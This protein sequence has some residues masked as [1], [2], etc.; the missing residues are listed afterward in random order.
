MDDFSPENV[1]GQKNGL[2]GR[3]EQ[4]VQVL[5]E[6]YS[7]LAHFA[8]HRDRLLDLLNACPAVDELHD[9]QDWEL[10]FNFVLFSE[11]FP[12]LPVLQPLSEQLNFIRVCMLVV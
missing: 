5:V 9:F 11:P 1:F 6:V 2:A 3:F 7:V 10:Q 4:L 12:F 8:P